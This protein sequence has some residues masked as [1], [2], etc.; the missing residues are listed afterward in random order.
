MPQAFRGMT[1]AVRQAAIDAGLE[2][3]IRTDLTTMYN[4]KNTSSTH[5]RRFNWERCLLKKLTE[6]EWKR[7]LECVDTNLKPYDLTVV[8]ALKF[9]PNRG[10]RGSVMIY[11]KAGVVTT[12]DELRKK[13]KELGYR[14]VKI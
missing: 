4:D 10:Y 13:A 8:N 7:F 9:G 6:T 12:V 5:D 3:K 14:L 11:V 1:G 2:K